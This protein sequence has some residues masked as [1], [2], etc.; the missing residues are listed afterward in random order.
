[1][2]LQGVEKICLEFHSKKSIEI[3]FSQTRLSSDGGLLPV[4]NFDE[5]IQLTEQFAAALHDG[6]ADSAVHS[7]LSMVR[8]R[9][10][11]ILAGYEDQNDHDTLRTDPVFQL[12][13]ER[14]PGENRDGLA[15]QPTLSRF[16]N[17]VSIADLWRLRDALLDEFLQAFETPPPTITLDIDA[18]DDT[19]HGQQQLTLF[20]GYY[21]QS[22]YFPIAITCAEND[23]VVLIGLRHGTAAAFLGVDDDLRYL[24]QRLRDVWPDVEIIVR[25]DAGFG[26]PMMYEVCEELEQTYTFGIGMNSVLKTR[27]DD[28]MDKATTQYNETKEKQR[29]FMETE[30][31]AGTWSQSRRVVIKCEAHQGGLNRRGVVTNRTDCQDDPQPIYDDYVQRGESENRNKELKCELC[32]DWLSD[33]RFM[34]NYFR[35]YLHASSLNLLIRLRQETEKGITPE[36]VGLPSEVL[37]KTATPSQKKLYFNRRRRA[38]PLGKGFACTWRTMFIKVSCEVQVSVRR[39]LVK[40][41]SHWPHLDEFRRVSQRIQ[42][43]HF[44]SG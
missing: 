15:S 16:E 42:A 18:F 9:I 39:V 25:A 21:H 38:D 11:G 1:M 13:C 5:K 8:Q 32:A 10:F 17:S 22:Q 29:L 36:K 19:T 31:Q 37:E 12:I 7:T 24:T 23:M 27:C 4:R 40:L 34:A 14:I 44:S 28:L 6:R 20:H 2:S 26:V 33:H 43:L 35:L 41:S 3:E 30:Y